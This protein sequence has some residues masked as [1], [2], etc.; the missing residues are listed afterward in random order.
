[1]LVLMGVFGQGGWN[2]NLLL[3]A[4]KEFGDPAVLITAVFLLYLCN[5]N[6]TQDLSKCG[7]QYHLHFSREDA[8]NTVASI[9]VQAHISWE[10]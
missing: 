1:M 10:F 3:L 4:T 9:R 8:I 7:F 6:N 5:S 2:G